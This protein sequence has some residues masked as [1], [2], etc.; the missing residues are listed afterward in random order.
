MSGAGQDQEPP[1]GDSG[2]EP[3]S[4]GERKERLL[5]AP[6]DRRSGRELALAALEAVGHGERP[7]GRGCGIAAVVAA[8]GVHDEAG[9]GERPPEEQEVED[10]PGARPVLREDAAALGVHVGGQLEPARVDEDELVHLLRMRERERGDG[11]APERM[12]DEIR[13]PE[14]EGAEERVQ[15]GHAAGDAVP[16]RVARRLAAPGARAVRQQDRPALADERAR[17]AGP[18][19]R[20]GAEAVHEDDGPLGRQR[21]EHPD[22]QARAVVGRED[23]AMPAGDREP[24]LHDGAVRGE[25]VDG[26]RAEEEKEREGDCSQAPAQEPLSV[27]HR[28]GAQYATRSRSALRMSS[29]CGSVAS[30]SCGA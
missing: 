15:R 21:S 18:V 6:D 1:A 17:G 10:P 3:S 25:R 28:A 19:R 2:R 29:L 26:E 5:L 16:G 4:E 23:L 9:G 14:R 20:V 30:S 12:A 8:E 22:G 24:F 7:H 11:P 13:L 27:A